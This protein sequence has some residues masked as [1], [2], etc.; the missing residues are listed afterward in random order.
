MKKFFIF[1]NKKIFY[2][3]ITNKK[4]KHLYITIHPQEGVIVKSPYGSH[5]TVEKILDSKAAWIDKKITLLST[6]QTIEQIY[7]KEKKLLLLGE[8]ISVDNIKDL[9]HFYKQKSVEIVTPLVQKHA[10]IMSLYPRRVAFRKAKRR[11]GSCSSRNDIS[12]NSSLCQLPI[13][14]IEYVII[15]ELA[16]I[17]HKHHQQSFWHTVAHFMPDYKQQIQQIRHYFPAISLKT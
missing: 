7:E 4:L 14:C 1:N 2:T 3:L 8:K 16:H 11:W 17:S 15:H 10:Q 13:R 6:K 5:D 9:N 12:F